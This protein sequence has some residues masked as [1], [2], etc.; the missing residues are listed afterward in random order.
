[1]DTARILGAAAII[2]LGCLAWAGCSGDRPAPGAATQ[3]PSATSATSP[4]ATATEAG[5]TGTP[6]ASPT[7]A[8]PTTTNT[9]PPPPAATKAAPK[10]S[11]P[12]TAAALPVPHGWHTVA[13]AGGPE[14]GY[15][16]NGTWVHGR[17]PRYAA[18]DVIAI[19]CSAITRDDYRD[20]L[21]ALEG[22]YQNAAGAP[23][24]GLVL[25]FS[26]PDPAARFYDLYRRQVE[27]CTATDNPVRTTI[28]PS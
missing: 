16:G 12:L 28:I 2:T 6:T 19:G 7:I 5:G 1:M 9:L 15:Q 17:D 4:V 3:L 10:K 18:Q 23:G 26:G 27:A 22:T 24:F 25:Q 20:P 11:G 8:E 14:E 13:L 21:H